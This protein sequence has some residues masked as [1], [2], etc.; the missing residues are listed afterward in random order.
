[1]PQCSTLGELVNVLQVLSQRAEGQAGIARPSQAA[2]ATI[3][4]SEALQLVRASSAYDG[5]VTRSD[6]VHLQQILRGVRQGLT[7][8][9]A[10]KADITTLMRIPEARRNWGE[11]MIRREGSAMLSDEQLS[12]IVRALEGGQRDCAQFMH[13][14]LVAGGGEGWLDARDD[15]VFGPGLA[16]I[17]SGA[18]ALGMPAFRGGG[19]AKLYFDT[20]IMVPPGPDASEYTKW[21]VAMHLFDTMRKVSVSMTYGSTVPVQLLASDMHSGPMADILRDLRRKTIPHE[22]A[23]ARDALRA[24]NGKRHAAP[25]ANIGTSSGARGGAQQASK[26]H[27]ATV[28]HDFLRGRCSRSHCQYHHDIKAMCPNGASC[29]FLAAGRCMFKQH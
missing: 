13:D 18:A 7:N 28:C 29:S 6:H 17:D 5:S 16:N 22:I 24:R 26:Q 2:T 9:H 1:M 15:S 20:T 21:L 14:V 27:R 19:A 8:M 25:P 10:E 11:A 23:T 3:A 4:T 12:A